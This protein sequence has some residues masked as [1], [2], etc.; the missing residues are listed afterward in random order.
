M[1]CFLN[2]YDNGISYFSY[3][4]DYS[5]TVLEQKATLEAQ[6]KKQAR[7]LSENGELREH[8][9][10]Q[11]KALQEKQ[12]KVHTLQSGITKRDRDVHL[13]R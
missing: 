13:M 3:R 8:I 12:A 11:E 10:K 7:F 9:S 5:S 1:R 6:S 2:R 4:A